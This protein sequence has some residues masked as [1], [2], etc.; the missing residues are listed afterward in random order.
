MLIGRNNEKTSNSSAIAENTSVS[1]NA[2]ANK[3]L[4]TNTNKDAVTKTPSI[5]ADWKYYLNN[6]LGIYFQY[7]SSWKKQEKDVE[8]V[9]LS[10][11]PTAIELAFDDTVLKSSFVL[12]YHFPPHGEVLFKHAESEFNSSTGWFAENGKQIEVAGTKA[13]WATAILKADGKGRALNPPIKTFLIYFRGEKKASEF[14]LQFKTPAP[15]IDIANSQLEH[16][17]SSF[18]FLTNN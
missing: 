12:I 16:L 10:N 13:L 17:L 6:K 4:S 2:K 7:P 9:N 18:R 1:T 5:N 14:E 8:S 15:V 11:E 3:E